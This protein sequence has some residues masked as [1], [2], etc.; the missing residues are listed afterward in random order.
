[1]SLTLSP[2]FT[3]SD[4]FSSSQAAEDVEHFCGMW[5]KK[6]KPLLAGLG[7]APGTTFPP[8][9]QNLP[10]LK[11]RLSDSIA[12]DSLEAK[13]K[14][15]PDL[16][17]EYRCDSLEDDING[18]D[19]DLFEFDIDSPDSNEDHDN[20]DLEDKPLINVIEDEDDSGRKESGVVLDGFSSIF[21]ST[22]SS[23]TDRRSILRQFED[24]RGM[25]VNPEDWRENGS[26]YLGENLSTFLAK[27]SEGSTTPILTVSPSVEQECP[28]ISPDSVI[29]EDSLLS[30]QDLCISSAI[31][32]S[33][34][35][36]SDSERALVSEESSENRPDTV[37]ENDENTQDISQSKVR[38][39]GWDETKNSVTTSQPRTDDIMMRLSEKINSRQS[40]EKKIK[41][42]PELTVSTDK[43]SNLLDKLGPIKEDSDS[44]DEEEEVTPLRLLHQ[45]SLDVRPKIRKCSSL[46]SSTTPTR[47]SSQRK[48]VRFADILGLDLSEVKVFMDDVPKV[49]KAAYADLDVNLSDLEIGSPVTRPLL[50]EPL[51]RIPRPAESSLVPMFN[52]PGG[53]SNFLQTVT[54]Q[55]V[56]LENAFMEG[57]S[58]VKG[59][60]RVVNLS[61]HKAVIVRWTVDNWQTVRETEAQYIIGSSQANTDKFS[62]RLPSP[63][64][65]A[66]DRLQFCLRYE[67]L[68]EHWDSNNGANYIFQVFANANKS[69]PE[70]PT[71]AAPVPRS[72]SRTFRL[73]ASQSPSQHGDDPW[74]RFM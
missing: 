20:S 71:A 39:D 1:M 7:P 54:S 19:E 11:Q 43:L 12:L 3:P 40:P 62:F 52:Q 21:G 69:T 66:G 5:I 44:N 47:S 24:S 4:R 53:S 15:E 45:N 67:C 64:L 22:N 27:S 26:F 34:H 70:C 51:Y 68:G 41:I 28:Y 73:S 63:S 37:S 46:K 2:L 42:L 50:S 59:I 8:F 56:C 61:F 57:P 16:N 33:F 65:K 29:E 6:H 72:Q 18:Q 25:S 14:S 55:K 10:Y 23:L 32:Q 35:E 31:E 13:W 49:P 38:S 36:S 30:D 17:A 74:L 9:S 58:S 60:V 48:I